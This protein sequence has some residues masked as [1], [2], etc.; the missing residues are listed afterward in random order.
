MK[1]KFIGTG[2]IESKCNPTSYLIDDKILIDCGNGIIKQLLKNN[3]DLDDINTV[4]ITHLHGDH[5]LDIPFLIMA[6]L[7]RNKLNNLKI[8]CPKN[9][10][11]TIKNLIKL[12]F[13]TENWVEKKEKANVEFIEFD[14][15]DN[16]NLFD[17]YYI[18]SYE[19]K[20]SDKIK[21]YGFVLNDNNKF[22]GFSGD[23][24]YCDNIDKIVNKSDISILDTTFI[25]GNEKHMGLDNIIDIINKHNKKVISTHMDDNTRKYILDNKIDNII[26]LEDS[27]EI[28][29]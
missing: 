6:K 15:L 9:T 10:I 23:S 1:I 2:S 8:Y 21:C 26:V 14:S 17:N 19:V 13:K 4:L 18:S 22:I 20:H 27:E 28:I 3:I 7:Y 24:S 16:F 5:F 25:N 29:L 11:E 12:S